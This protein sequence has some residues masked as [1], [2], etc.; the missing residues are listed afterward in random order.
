[1]SVVTRIA[2]SPT[3]HMH[4]GTARTALYNWLFARHHG[5]RFHIRIEDTDR[6]RH[7]EEA[8]LAILNGMKWL[9]LDW[10]G[11]VVSQFEQ[12]GAMPKLPA[13]YW[14]KVMPISVSAH[15]KSWRKCAKRPKRKAGLSIM[16]GG[17]AIVTRKKRRMARPM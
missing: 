11:D 16:T 13:R 14:K 4:I 5:G 10:D 15:L 8:V 17:G 3:G 6:A 1:M 7:N 2:P 12:R 9:E